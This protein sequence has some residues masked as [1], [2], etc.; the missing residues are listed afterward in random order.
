MIVQIYEIQSPKEAERCIELGVDHI[1]SVVLSKEAWKQREIR[2]VADICRAENKK[3]SIIPLFREAGLI[4]QVLDYYRPDIIHFCDSLVDGTGKSE[5]LGE[6]I[7][8]QEEIRLH[9]PEVKI[10]R[11][12]PIPV[13]KN[14]S[15][16]PWLKIAQQMEPVT[17]LFLTDT[18]LGK[19]PVEGFIGIT[20]IRCSSD[21]ARSLVEQSTIPVILAGGL[22]PDNVYE[23]IKETSAFGADSC[24]R[25][26]ILDKHRNPVRFKKDF[27]KVKSFVQEVRKAENEPGKN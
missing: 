12:I 5:N 24:T 15:D 7:T 8:L 16:F 22:S 1:G 10:M 3:S 21:M 19:E 11:S 4:R 25:T 20:G 26:N 23:A 14:N 9:F 18:W 27:K 6:Y 13:N 2:E 17:D